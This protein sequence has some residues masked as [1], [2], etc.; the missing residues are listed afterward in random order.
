MVQGDGGGNMLFGSF[1][2][3]DAYFAPVVM[4][5]MTYAVALPPA[6]QRYCEAVREL[7]AVRQWM[8]GARA[9]T[10]FGPADEPYAAV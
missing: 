2:A 1:G 4:R 3:V 10:E 8:D 6:A 7:A 5:F 9:E